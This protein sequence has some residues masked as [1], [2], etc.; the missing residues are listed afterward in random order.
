MPPSTKPLKV[1]LHFIK[2]LNADN[3]FAGLNKINRSQVVL[4]FCLVADH[5]SLLLDNKFTQQN[6]LLI[7]KKG[8]GMSENH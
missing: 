8:G 7:Q 5:L 3:T 2:I 6:V 1:P 4:C